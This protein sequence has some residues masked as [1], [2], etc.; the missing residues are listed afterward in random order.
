M[1]AV[2]CAV[3]YA[4]AWRPETARKGSADVALPACR[5]ACSLDRGRWS[6]A[7]RLGSGSACRT[8]IDAFPGPSWQ[9]RHADMGSDLRPTDAASPI[10]GA[11]VRMLSV[12]HPGAQPWRPADPGRWP[13]R[14]RSAVRRS[15]T[16][17]SVHRRAGHS[18]PGSCAGQDRGRSGAASGSSHSSRR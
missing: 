11:T 6:E 4:R 8:C 3:R 14:G 10:G 12:W 18:A 16:P 7:R 17:L 5:S 15:S 1:A 2:G 13:S 9:R